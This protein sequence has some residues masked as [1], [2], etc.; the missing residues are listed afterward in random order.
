[1][2]TRKKHVLV[3]GCFDLLH[4]G[5]IAFLEEASHHGE[6]IVGIGSDETVKNLKGRYPVYTEQE[7]KYLLESLRCVKRCTINSGRGILD[8]VGDLD[9]IRPDIL[10]VNEDGNSPEKEELC[11]QRS[12]EYIVSRRIPHGT[13]PS[14]STTGLRSECTIP[15]RIDLAGGWLDQPFV[16]KYCPGAVLTISIEPTIEFH[17]RSGMATSTRRKAIELW[18]NELPGGDREQLAKVLFSF[19]NPPG[20]EVISGSQ[21]AIGIV[22][23]GLNRLNYSGRYWPEEIESCRQEE[24]L[25]W[26]ENSLSLVTL[27]PRDDGYSVLSD[28]NISTESASRLAAAADNCW[29]AILRKDIVEF[30]RSFA[31]SFEA[32]VAMFP[33]MVDGS[34]RDVLNSYNS[35]ALGWKLSGAGGGGYIILISESQISGTI[36]IKIRRP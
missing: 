23:P 15:Y 1:M 5:H 13:L 18:K 20:T 24:I 33:H 8:F 9:S 27:G 11:R 35:R 4:S 19:D 7:R 2:E 32:Q 17:E 21:D 22:L 31:E 34:L 10:F 28:S 16:S 36:K 14:R 12:I 6:L 25:E 30:G 26:L 29:K 3:T